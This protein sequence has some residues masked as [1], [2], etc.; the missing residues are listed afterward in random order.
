MAAVGPHAGRLQSNVNRMEI[1]MKNKTAFL[2]WVASAAALAGLG[3]TPVLAQAPAGKP[4]GVL[5]AS[6]SLTATVTKVDSKDRWVTL[7]LADG[8]TFDVQAGPEVKNFAQIK[9]GDKV[10][11]S[12]D[13]TVAIAVVSGDQAPPMASS[14]STTTSAPL[15]AKPMGVEVDLVTLSG[16]VT[17][18]DYG[19]R[20]VTLVGPKGNSHTVQVGPAVQR[21]DNIKQGD[22]VVLNIKRVTTIQVAAPGK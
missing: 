22:Q 19:K 9:V 13:E 20:L 14:G 8:T 21:F 11:A 3:T 12:Q 1:S 2:A 10:T 5:A 17:A 15:G 4:A 16:K 6:A 7:K 18:I